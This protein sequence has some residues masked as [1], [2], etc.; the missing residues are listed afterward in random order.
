MNYK[1]TFSYI[2][3]FAMVFSLMQTFALFSFAEVN[4]KGSV[5][6]D[7][8]R[9]LKSELPTD[10]TRQT[11]GEH[12]KINGDNG[13]YFVYKIHTWLGNSASFIPLTLERRIEK[14][15]REVMKEDI[16]VTVLSGY[17][18]VLS[19]YRGAG[20]K[21]SA[22]GK[23]LLR[24]QRGVDR[25][26]V[27]A[28]IV[29][30][31]DLSLSEPGETKWTSF[32]EAERWVMDIDYSRYLHRNKTLITEENGIPL[33][34]DQQYYT[35]RLS[36]S[37]SSIELFTEEQL[38]NRL[39]WNLNWVNA[40][41]LVVDGY[42]E[43]YAKLSQMKN[44]GSSTDIYKILI[45]NEYVAEIEITVSVGT[46]FASGNMEY[47]F[48]SVSKRRGTRYSDSKPNKIVRNV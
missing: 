22:S 45:D 24:I 32:L 48:A 8:E 4:A 41:G 46:N 40:N 15:Y 1:K 2:L 30:H 10:N 26:E 36:T 47:L 38:N 44:G 35:Y 25:C 13:Y 18:E 23:F 5:E 12:A 17:E 3:V 21:M 42:K 28:E 7:W 16:Q 19:K 43:A 37:F 11:Y 27:E 6:A 34:E 20:D 9:Y 31:K 14:S 33:P 29:V 39:N